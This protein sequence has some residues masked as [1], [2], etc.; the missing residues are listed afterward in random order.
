MTTIS[1][2]FQTAMDGAIFMTSKWMG[3]TKML[4]KKLPKISIGHVLSPWIF[5]STCPNPNFS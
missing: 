2:W 3:T 4:P 5:M 1:T